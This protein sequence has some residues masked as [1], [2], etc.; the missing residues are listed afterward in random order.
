MSTLYCTKLDRQGDKTLSNRGSKKSLVLLYRNI[1]VYRS[2]TQ[3]TSAS[4]TALSF[5]LFSSCLPSFPCI[6]THAFADDPKEDETFR[7]IFFIFPSSFVYQHSIIARLKVEAEAPR[8]SCV[9][10][11]SA[12]I[13]SSIP[14]RNSSQVTSTP[15]SPKEPKPGRQALMPIRKSLSACPLFFFFILA[16]TPREKG[17]R[18]QEGKREKITHTKERSGCL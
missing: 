10:V 17:E 6:A 14:K 4:A 9:C 2:S 3:S 11:L 16:S 5:P 8:P 12:G 15:L 18:E 13:L 7:W 1:Q